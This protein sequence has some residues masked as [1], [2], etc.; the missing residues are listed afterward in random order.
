M[1]TIGNA[2]V[3]SRDLIVSV[4][5]K[6]EIVRSMEKILKDAVNTNK[7]EDKTEDSMKTS[8]LP[9]TSSSTTTIIVDKNEDMLEKI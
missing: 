8:E 5:S 1:R 2:A 9:P 3:G 7:L 6:F 4:D